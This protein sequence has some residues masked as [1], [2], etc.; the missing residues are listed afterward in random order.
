MVLPSQPKLVL[1]LLTPSKY[2]LGP[3]LVNFV[4]QT[5]VINHYTTLPTSDSV[6]TTGREKLPKI[7][8]GRDVLTHEIKTKQVE[9]L[10]LA[11]GWFS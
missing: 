9:M 11:A 6:V 5:N 3:M 4:H 2:S 1:I 10:Y 7:Y 8:P